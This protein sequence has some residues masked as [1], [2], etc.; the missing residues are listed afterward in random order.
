[1]EFADLPE[2]WKDKIKPRSCPVEPKVDPV[3]EDLLARAPAELDVPGPVD[4]EVDV[5]DAYSVDGLKWLRFATGGA[6][7]HGAVVSNEDLGASATL[8]GLAAIIRLNLPPPEP[9]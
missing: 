3:L 4:P 9:A 1:M 2:G 7:R 5:F 8:N 6:E